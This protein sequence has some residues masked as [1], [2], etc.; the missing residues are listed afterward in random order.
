MT[1]QDFFILDSDSTF[2]QLTVEDD[3][4]YFYN[5]YKKK[6]F[7]VSASLSFDICHLFVALID[8]FIALVSHVFFIVPSFFTLLIGKQR[9]YF[10]VAVSWKAL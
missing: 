5:F 7:S 2:F 10:F 8:Y 3:S 9:L 4:V 6:P 1:F